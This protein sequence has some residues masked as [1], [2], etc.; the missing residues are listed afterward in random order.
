V[1]HCYDPAPPYEARGYNIR[2][3]AEPVPAL[4]PSHEIGGP[5]DDQRARLRLVE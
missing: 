4:A 1:T 3:V 2:L 5:H